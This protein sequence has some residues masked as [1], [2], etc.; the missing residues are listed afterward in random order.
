MG[1]D[2]EICFEIEVHIYAEERLCDE[3]LEDGAS[4]GILGPEVV[5]PLRR[6]RNCKFHYQ[7]SKSTTAADAIRAI[8]KRIECDSEDIL[9]VN[10]YCVRFLHG[11][12]RYLVSNQSKDLYSL[13]RNYF[14]PEESG[15]VFVQILVCADAGTIFQED[16]IRFFMN[17]RE[18]GKHKAPH[19]HVESTGHE[20]SASLAISD[21][22]VLAGKFPK[23]LL[24]KARKKINDEQEYFYQCWQAKTDGLISDINRRFGYTNY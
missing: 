3:I 19:V 16:G 12:E 14:D 11:T 20:Y 21:G 24:K 9:V 23:K 17:S 18:S 4:C 5:L 6:N 15:R 10:D 13:L 22:K 7:Y 8:L 2:M 1:D